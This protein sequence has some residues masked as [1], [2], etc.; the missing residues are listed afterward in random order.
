MYT[1]VLDLF[2]MATLA[3]GTA[4]GRVPYSRIPAVGVTVRLPGTAFVAVGLSPGPLVAVAGVVVRLGAE[5]E[6][7]RGV[8][9]GADSVA[10]VVACA[11]GEETATTGVAVAV[12]GTVVGEG[13]AANVSSAEVR[14]TESIVACV[15]TSDTGLSPV[16]KNEQE[17]AKTASKVMKTRS[18]LIVPSLGLGLADD[19]QEL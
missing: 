19:L 14:T 11:V 16:C 9:E 8:D 3:K 18:L 5:V 17:L 13:R 4:G 1:C 2:I 15:S 7:G 10:V 12:G 6:E